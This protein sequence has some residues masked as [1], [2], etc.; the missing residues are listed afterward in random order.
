MY[1]RDSVL[2]KK[3]FDVIYLDGLHTFEQT[4]RD[5]LNALTLVA[6]AGV[7]I[8]DDVLPSSFAALLTDMEQ[9]FTIRS[10]AKHVGQQF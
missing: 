5:L 4:L 2:A 6:D 1:F 10:M 8:L 7:I 3:K 9:V